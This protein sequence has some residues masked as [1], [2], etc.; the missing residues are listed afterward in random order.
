MKKILCLFI[1]LFIGCAIF[2]CSINDD[3]GNPP[4]TG[5]GGDSNG[6]GENGYGENGNGENNGDE[7]IMDENCLFVTDITDL[8]KRNI[9]SI[10][11][12]NNNNV[13][14]STEH[15]IFNVDLYTGD[16]TKLHDHTNEY[17]EYASEI[18]GFDGG[19]AVLTKEEIFYYNDS[20]ELIKLTKPE[21]PFSFDNYEDLAISPDGQ[22]LLYRKGYDLCISDVDL[23]NE[24]ILLYG[25]Y[26]DDSSPISGAAYRYPV[27]TDG[28]QS[29]WCDYVGWEWLIQTL[30][31]GID[32]EILLEIDSDFSS[33]KYLFTD[34]SN[35]QYILNI[36]TLEY[37][38][39][40]VS[41]LY[42]YKPGD[43]KLEYINNIEVDEEVNNFKHC[44]IND[45]HYLYS[46]KNDIVYITDIESLKTNKFL[47]VENDE[48]ID[49]FDIFNDRIVLFVR[50][51]STNKKYLKIMETS[52]I[53]N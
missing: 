49:K 52:V 25:E 32:G 53:I 24:K 38:V 13:I 23:N 22:M 1:I 14:F 6:S 26:P 34:E 30:H 15:G 11:A 46:D 36:A 50:D 42:I 39:E 17:G 5:D 4:S 27:F 3:A 40:Y 35:T 31:V 28:G 10:I 33:Y 44:I 9:R 20:H 12:K 7:N 43:D 2:G 19:Y 45:T 47:L 48:H 16:I 29:F 21:N 37:F 18:L 41:S 8:C 51:S